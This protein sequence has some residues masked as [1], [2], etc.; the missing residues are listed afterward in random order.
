MKKV[1]VFKKEISYINDVNIRKDLRKLISLLPDYFFEVPVSI[2]EE[3]N[4]CGSLVKQ[5][6]AS[7]RIAYELLSNNTMGSRFSSRDKDL[8]IMAIILC[9]GLRYG[10][11]LEDSVRFDHPL[12]MSKFIM[13]NKDKLSLDID[14]IR[15]IC[16]MIE[17]HNGEWTVDPKTE[18]EILPKPR[19][20]EQRFVHICMFLASRKFIEVKFD[21]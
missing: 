13:M 3:N 15:K 17:A 12:L 19:T 4:D 2:N 14:D 11:K 9:D 18:K 20:E 6:K 10:E 5:I 1:S 7:V 16:S 8:I 21:S